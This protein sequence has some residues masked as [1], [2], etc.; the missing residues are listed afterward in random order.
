MELSKRINLSNQI[1]DEP[2]MRYC[3]IYK[4]TNLTTQKMYV[5]QAVSHI[6]NHGKYRPYGK[7]ARFRCHVSEAFSKKKCQSTYL[8]NAIKKYGVDDFEICILEYCEINDADTRETYH[9]MNCDSLFPNGYNLKFGGKQFQHTPE[10]KKRVS[11]GIHK[12]YS[13]Q[14]ILRFKDVGLIDENIEK[15][16][17]PLNRSKKQY[18]WYVYIENKKADFGGTHI[19]L[20]DSKQMAIDFI[21]KLRQ[22]QLATHLDAGNPLEPLTTTS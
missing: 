7:D 2:T 1:L 4:I 5:G 6:L 15:Y 21:N 17:R 11:I 22:E 20:N 14:K 18:G 16:I 8:N 10:S 9:I 3:E 12:Y 13:E 19:S